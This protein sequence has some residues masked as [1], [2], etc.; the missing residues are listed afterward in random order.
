MVVFRTVIYIIIIILFG[1]LGYAW[2]KETVGALLF[3]EKKQSL[4]NSA[5]RVG[6][7]ERIELQ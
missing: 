7:E 1:V 2:A 6:I 3:P 5:L 4:V